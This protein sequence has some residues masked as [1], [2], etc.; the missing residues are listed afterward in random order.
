MSKSILILFLA[1][2]TAAAGAADLKTEQ[3]KTLYA[4]GL[5]IAQNLTRYSLSESELDKL[6]AGLRDG[7]LAAE[8]AVDLQAYGPK[9]QE[10]AQE[11]AQASLGAEKTASVAFIEKM[12]QTK[13]AQKLDSGLIYIPITEGSGESPAATDTVSVHYHGTLRDGSVFDSS[14]DRGET[15]SF[16]LNRVIP[17]WTEGLQLMK[18]GGKATLVCP[19]DIAYGERG[20][21]P[22]IQPGAALRFEVELFGIE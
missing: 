4:L 17:C 2:T 1:L 7:V 5:M 21:P 10:L 20:S 18:V 22:V 3:D 13:G 16:P 11:R 14:V 15:I 19:S 6:S 8:P 9:I 12:A